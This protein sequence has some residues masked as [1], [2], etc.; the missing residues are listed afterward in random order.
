MNA[1]TKLATQLNQSPEVALEAAQTLAEMGEDA[2]PAAVALMKFGLS[3]DG[4]VRDWSVAALEQMGPPAATDVVPLRSLLSSD[5]E[6]QAYWAATLL[7]RIGSEANA[8]VDDLARLV[9]E[10]PSS[11]VRQRAAGALGQIGEVTPTVVD[12]LKHAAACDDT[13]LSRI[14]NDALASLNA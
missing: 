1:A 7:G 8:A 14:A 13:R 12:S 5:N 2:Q 3:A 9:R 11:A 10:S 6:L 4:E